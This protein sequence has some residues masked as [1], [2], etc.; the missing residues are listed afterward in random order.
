[1]FDLR[2][3]PYE[4]NNVADDPDY[5]DI[6]AT[7]LAELDNWRRNVIHDQGVSEEFR[8]EDVFP[9]SCPTAKV[10]RARRGSN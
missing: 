5:A 1:M 3:D 2:H 9:E 10:D 7:L 4:V 8:A 6:R